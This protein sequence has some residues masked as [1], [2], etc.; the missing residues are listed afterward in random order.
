[1]DFVPEESAVNTELIEVDN[2]TMEMLRGLNM[3]NLP[4][5][6][7]Q[8]VSRLMPLQHLDTTIRTALHC[9]SMGVLQTALQHNPQ[10]PTSVARLRLSVHTPQ[11]YLLEFMAT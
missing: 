5:V 7:L 6:K 11:L 3:A 10:V 9:M 4:G 8:Q 1:M 2:D